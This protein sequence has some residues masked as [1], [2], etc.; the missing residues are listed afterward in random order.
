MYKKSKHD[1]IKVDWKTRR[2]AAEEVKLCS[3]NQGVKP[4][5]HLHAGHTAEGK[6]RKL[7]VKRKI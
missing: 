2:R 6:Q 1:E 5:R 4:G 7:N 3:L